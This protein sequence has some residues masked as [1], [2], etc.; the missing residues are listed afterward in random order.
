MK[1]AREL[2]ALVLSPVAIYI[3]GWSHPYLFDATIALISSL[4]L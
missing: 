3:I 4:A 1:Y 2:T